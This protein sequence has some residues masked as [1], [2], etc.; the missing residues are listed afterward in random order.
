MQNYKRYNQ[1]K[2]ISDIQIVN[3]NTIN[4][5]KKNKRYGNTKNKN[6]K[7]RKNYICFCCK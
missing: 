6:L 1:K 3:L 4:S 5:E 2:N 7:Y